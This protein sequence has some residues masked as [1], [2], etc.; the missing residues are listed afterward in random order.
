MV[1]SSAAEFF[2][3]GGYGPYVWGSVAVTFGFMALEIFLV[4]HRRRL[5]VEILARD[6]VLIDDG[7]A[8]PSGNNDSRVD[9]V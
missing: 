3:M 2:S 5:A 9:T 1:W 7:D 4:R 8:A 6:R